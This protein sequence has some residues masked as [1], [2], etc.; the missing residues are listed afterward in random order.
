MFVELTIAGNLNHPL[1]LFCSFLMNVCTKY[2]N[3]TNYFTRANKTWKLTA[4]STVG[5]AS[6]QQPPILWWCV[7]QLNRHL[8]HNCNLLHKHFSNFM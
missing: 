2:G 4:A 5:T 6:E 3:P 7:L 8:S 1:L